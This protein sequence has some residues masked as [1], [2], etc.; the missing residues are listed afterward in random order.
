MDEFLG[1]VPLASNFK[2]KFFPAT[3]RA[4]LKSDQNGYIDIKTNN[5][6]ALAQGG[7]GM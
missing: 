3:N 5:L 4:I 7:H 2:S 6:T 1:T